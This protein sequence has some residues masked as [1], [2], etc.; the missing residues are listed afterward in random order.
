MAKR[1]DSK[2]FYASTLK[3]EVTE[4]V[5]Q[6][7]RFIPNSLNVGQKIIITIHFDPSKKG[8]LIPEGP[9]IPK[10]YHKSRQ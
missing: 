7:L 10:E 1:S 2:T 8:S 6:R 5:E 4:W 9:K 3:S